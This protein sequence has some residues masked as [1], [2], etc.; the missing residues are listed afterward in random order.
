MSDAKEGVKR[1]VWKTK[2]VAGLRQPWVS[3]KRLATSNELTG[4]SS[5]Q[6]ED[7]VYATQ[8]SESIRSGYSVSSTVNSKAKSWDT[9]PG[10]PLSRQQ[11]PRGDLKDDSTDNEH[12]ATIGPSVSLSSV[13]FE[14]KP[15]WVSSTKVVPPAQL[16][17][18]LRD[19]STDSAVPAAFDG[20]CAQHHD[21]RPSWVRPNEKQKIAKTSYPIP[22]K[23]S[24]PVA[25]PAPATSKD[26]DRRGNASQ[27]NNASQSKRKKEALPKFEG[28]AKTKMPPR[29]IG[30]A[31]AKRQRA[32]SES[33][34]LADGNHATAIS[35]LEEKLRRFYNVN[36]PEKIRDNVPFEAA[37]EFVDKEDE[38]NAKLRQIYGSDLRDELVTTAI[39]TD[40]AVGPS[41]PAN[42]AVPKT[43]T[44]P[45]VSLID[46]QEIEV[47]YSETDDA[48]REYHKAKLLAEQIAAEQVTSV[49]KH[50]PQ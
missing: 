33:W 32:G 6:T 19:E 43:K 41:Q 48:M 28:T 50:G 17:D 30:G 23:P 31:T 1:I 39:P 29:P 2:P 27:P 12:S 3:S 37:K 34:C 5:A 7:T 11:T 18:S 20:H 35:V 22:A 38:L 46:E 24:P 47:A 8:S 36:A 10:Y 16:F 9:T 13:S 21:T 40:R 42:R 49:C 26:K 14:R 15:N 45:K 4:L 25:K 44:K